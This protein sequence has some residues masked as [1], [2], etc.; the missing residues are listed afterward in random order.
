MST[1]S[2]KNREIMYLVI[3]MTIMGFSFYNFLKEVND[4]GRAQTILMREIAINE[5]VTNHK[6][7]ANTYIEKYVGFLYRTPG[8]KGS[9]FTR[10]IAVIGSVILLRVSNLLMF[11][12]L[13]TVVWFVLGVEGYLA[14]KIK[15]LEFKITS[16]V[17]FHYVQRAY[18]LFYAVVI[19]TYLCVGVYI[20]P[21][22]ICAALIGISAIT[23]YVVFSNVPIGQL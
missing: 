5:V 10:N 15:M 9:Q 18:F 1:G 6:V 22:A 23:S 7:Y 4:N 11:L 14:Q 12:P 17:L 8:E 20:N 3:I 16:P 13:I 19:T 21:Y 2:F